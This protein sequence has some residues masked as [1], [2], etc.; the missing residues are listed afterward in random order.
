MSAP[1]IEWQL[2]SDPAR[3]VSGGEVALVVR[4]Y[5]LDWYSYQ[6]LLD[7]KLD[8]SEICKAPIV[9]VDCPV[10]SRQADRL[11]RGYFR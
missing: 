1:P 10:P 9:G 6:P 5:P 4:V 7:T 2:D 8:F 11:R 3:R